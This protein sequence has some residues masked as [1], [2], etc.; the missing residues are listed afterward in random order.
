MR[1]H[2]GTGNL[3]FLAKR[4]RASRRRDENPA[5]ASSSVRDPVRRF[6][7]RIARRIAYEVKKSSPPRLEARE[8]YLA[9][10]LLRD[11]YKDDDGLSAAELCVFSQNGEDGVLAEIF[12]RIGVEKRFFVEFGVEDG[13][14]CNTRFLAEVLGWSGV[15]FECDPDGF[16]ALAQRLSNRP[17]LSVAQRMMTPANINEEFAAAGVPGEFD[18]LSV[19]VDGQDYWIWEALEGYS[20]RVVVIEYNSGLAAEES[21]VEPKT[22]RAW[23]ETDY[24]GASLGAIRALGEGKGYRLVHCELAGVNAFFV[25]EDLAAPFT[26]PPLPRGPNFNLVG[27]R[28]TSGTCLLYTF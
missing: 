8:Q 11:R 18:L 3:R 2:S 10:A 21:R 6:I 19:D 9:V 16:E 17:D 20:P 28:H 1:P 24:F 4:R 26:V 14:E 7:D 5:L 25:R 23:D 27:S 22:S 12:S 15:Y 13:V